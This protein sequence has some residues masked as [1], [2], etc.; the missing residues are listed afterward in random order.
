MLSAV[1]TPV[2][3]L[4]AT[5]DQFAVWALKTIRSLSRAGEQETVSEV[6]IPLVQPWLPTQQPLM[7]EA[8]FNSAVS[9]DAQGQPISQL[10]SSS[11][12]GWKGFCVPCSGR[13]SPRCR[14][15]KSPKNSQSLVFHGRLNRL[16]V[17]F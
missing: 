16:A 6:I 2:T 10:R 3:V 8:D 1:T 11:C 17:G 14:Q 7:K 5:V 9:G 12:A 15:S 4:P 13:S